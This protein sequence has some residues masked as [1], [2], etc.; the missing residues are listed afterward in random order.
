MATSS[1]PGRQE[2]QSMCPRRKKIRT[3]GCI[4]LSVP[5]KQDS[6]SNGACI[7]LGVTAAIN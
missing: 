7:L 6:P 1:F 4:P 2:I 5:D 3:C